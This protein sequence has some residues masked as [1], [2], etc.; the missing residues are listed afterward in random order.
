M[1]GKF[2]EKLINQDGY[3]MNIK[4]NFP[5]ADTI[6]ETNLKHHCFA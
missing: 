1:S 2:T 6:K 4:S 3:A 5:D